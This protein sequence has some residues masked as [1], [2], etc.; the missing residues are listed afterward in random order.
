MS[1]EA[2]GLDPRKG[3]TSCTRGALDVGVNLQWV[4]GGM[5]G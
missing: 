2:T 5:W 1:V 3:W 4:D